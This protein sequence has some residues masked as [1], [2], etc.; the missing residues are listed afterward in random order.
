ML[1]MPWLLYR[2]LLYFYYQAI[3]L[4][5]HHGLVL[6]WRKINGL[7]VEIMALDIYLSPTLPYITTGIDMLRLLV[8]HTQPLSFSQTDSFYTLL[9]S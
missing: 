4:I 3:H 9:Q 7:V 2:F 1:R 5:R 6:A 8:Q